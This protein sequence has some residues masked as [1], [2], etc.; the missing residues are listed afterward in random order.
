MTLSLISFRK[1]FVF[2]LERV[3]M[4]ATRSTATKRFFSAFYGSRPSAGSRP[5]TTTFYPSHTV[6]YRG[7]EAAVAAKEIKNA[8]RSRSRSVSSVERN[9]IPRSPNTTHRK[10]ESADI[11]IT[12]EQEDAEV[13][14]AD[15]EAK[16]GRTSER[17]RATSPTSMADERG[18][19]TDLVLIIHGIGQGV[20]Y[21]KRPYH[22]WVKIC[23]SAYGPIRRIQLCLR[24]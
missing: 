1:S 21:T 2:V 14:S 22:H 3:L 17:E 20:R 23:F 6:V 5:H 11:A 7:Y 12:L 15:F 9:G 10:S 19:V 8:A 24:G 13:K 16:R 18:D 4:Q